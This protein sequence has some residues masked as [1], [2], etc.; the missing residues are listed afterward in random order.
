MEEQIYSNRKQYMWFK[1]LVILCV[2]A[3]VIVSLVMALQKNDIEHQF[4]VTA[5]GKITATPD[6]ATIMIGVYTDAKLTAAEAVLDNTEKMNQII[7]ALKGI[8]IEKKDIETSNYNLN[9]M[10]DWTD[11]EG[12]RLIGYEVRQNVTIKIRDLDNIG[13]AI[14]LTT[15]K[16][17]NQI[18]GI[19]FTIDDPDE[20]K[21]EA[22]KIAIEKAK[23]KAE[24]LSRDSGLKI[25]KLINVY[26][27][28]GYYPDLRTNKMYAMD[29]VLGMGGSVPEPTIEAGEQEVVVEMTLVY[30]VK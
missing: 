11:R 1:V 21:A 26:E 8:D 27:S 18:G 5:T 24:E 7:A 10:Y 15:E 12:R 14:Q 28:Q 13:S 25:G 30:E 29:E 22:R 2:T 3:I 19:N 16:G 23:V 4:S 17:A 6:I 9:P 20:L